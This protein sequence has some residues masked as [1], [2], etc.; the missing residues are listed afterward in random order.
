MD[1]A[2][3]DNTSYPGNDDKTGLVQCVKDAACD[4]GEEPKTEPGKGYGKQGRQ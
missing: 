3:V 4:C 2:R 1:R